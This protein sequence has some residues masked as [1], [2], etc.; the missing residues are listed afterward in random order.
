MRALSALLVLSG[1]V[2]FAFAA[3]GPSQDPCPDKPPIWFY[4]GNAGV[5]HH[6]GACEYPLPCGL[7]TSCQLQPEANWTCVQP[8]EQLGACA[9][10]KSYSTPW[11]CVRGF[12]LQSDAG[13]ADA[14]SGG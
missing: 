8:N 3:C 9:Y 11:D 5:L 4:Q 13:P 10:C 1:G 12:Y 14:A 7:K 2:A 6:D